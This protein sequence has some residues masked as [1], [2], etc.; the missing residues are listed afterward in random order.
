[1]EHRK[2]KQSHLSFRASV[3]GRGGCTKLYFNFIEHKLKKNLLQS[4][5][6]LCCQVT[7]SIIVCFNFEFVF[8]EA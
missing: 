5:S 3:L 2:N 1:M 8:Y 4:F 6:L 7:S